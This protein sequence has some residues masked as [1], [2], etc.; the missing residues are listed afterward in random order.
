MKGHPPGWPHEFKVLIQFNIIRISYS[1]CLRVK[2]K[3]P[4][5]IT[6]TAATMA[7]ALISPPN[8]SHSMEKPFLV[9]NSF[10]VHT[11]LFRYGKFEARL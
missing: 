7:I 3:I 1:M 8:S 5:P 6:A 2:K 10:T 4:N 11:L 9:S